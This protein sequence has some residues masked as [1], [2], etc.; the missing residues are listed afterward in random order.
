MCGWSSS[1]AGGLSRRASSLTIV[2]ADVDPESGDSAVEPEAQDPVELVATSSFHQFRSGCVG[3][4]VVEVVL[5]AAL[6]ERPGGPAEGAHPVVR[7][8]AVGLGVRPHVPVRCARSRADR[9][10]SN[11]GCRSLV[12]FGTRSRRTRMPRSRASATS[13]SRSSSVPS[14]GVDVAVVGDVVAPVRVRRGH[15]RVEPDAVDAE[16]LE[17]VEPRLIPRRSPMPSAFESTND[18]G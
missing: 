18:R 4:E 14:V 10:S 11:H 1:V 13:R 3:Q 6:V 7:R 12:W 2:C 8:R 9:A 16:P 5:A 15:D 17:V